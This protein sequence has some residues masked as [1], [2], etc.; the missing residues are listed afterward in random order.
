MKGIEDQI[1]NSATAAEAGR[2]Q[3]ETVESQIEEAK[4]SLKVTHIRIRV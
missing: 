3:R 4:K 2:K 1:R